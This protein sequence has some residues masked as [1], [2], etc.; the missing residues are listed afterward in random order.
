MEN[1]SKRWIVHSEGITR[2]NRKQINSMVLYQFLL[3]RQEKIPVI[4]QVIFMAEKYTPKVLPE[5]L[6]YDRSNACVSDRQRTLFDSRVA[7]PGK[8][9]SCCRSHSSLRPHS[10]A[11]GVEQREAFQ[12]AGQGYQADV[13]FHPGRIGDGEMGDLLA[14]HKRV[15]AKRDQLEK[16][17]RFESSGWLN[18]GGREVESLIK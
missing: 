16:A 13:P 14:T 12:R 9:A 5:R 6:A 17:L 3:K 8:T 18:V 2:W 4:R 7:R 15:R 1:D 11:V 10:P